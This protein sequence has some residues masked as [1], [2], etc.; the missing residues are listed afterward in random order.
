MKKWYIEAH[1]AIT[2]SSELVNESDNTAPMVFD[3][4]KEAITTLGIL[5]MTE[6]IEIP[7]GITFKVVLR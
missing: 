2:N 1:N 3:T 5:Y 7:D 6:F 4:E